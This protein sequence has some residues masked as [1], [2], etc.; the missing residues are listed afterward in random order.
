[1]II[2]IGK[3]EIA[4]LTAAR[5]GNSVLYAVR[6][7]SRGPPVVKMHACKGYFYRPAQAVKPLAI[8][9]L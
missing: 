3:I 2:I 8:K 7:C 4:T 9:R 1:M 6:A 5:S